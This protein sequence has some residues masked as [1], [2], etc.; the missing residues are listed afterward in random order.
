[1]ITSGPTEVEVAP[2]PAAAALGIGLVLTVSVWRYDSGPEAAHWAATAAMAV[3]SIITLAVAF[4]LRF[5]SERRGMLM[6]ITASLFATVGI[7]LLLVL[8]FF[9]AAPIAIALAVATTLLLLLLAAYAVYHMA[10]TTHS[11]EPR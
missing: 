4:G 3:V 2:I 6:R 1:M 7:P 5:R 8:A 10:E 11:A 9:D